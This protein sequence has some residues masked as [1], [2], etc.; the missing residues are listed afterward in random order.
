MAALSAP[1]GPASNLSDG[2]IPIWQYKN[3]KAAQGGLVCFALQTFENF[4]L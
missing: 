1:L 3:K 4:A 2:E